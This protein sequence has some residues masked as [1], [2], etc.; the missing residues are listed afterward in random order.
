MS[1]WR[2]RLA[3][4]GRHTPALVEGDP[5]APRGQLAGALE[6]LGWS[7]GELYVDGVHWPADDPLPVGGSLRHGSL[8]GDRAVDQRAVDVGRHVVVVA[9]PA[10]GTIAPLVP[11]CSVVVGREPASDVGRSAVPLA[12][13]DRL[14]SG[15]HCEFAVTAAGGVTVRDLGSR[16]GTRADGVLVSH[17]P[18]ELRAAAI[19]HAGASLLTVLEIAGDERMTLLGSS[20]AGTTVQRQFREAVPPLPDPPRPPRSARDHAAVEGGGAWLRSL[21]PIVTAV[22]MALIT[23]RWWFLAIG[24]LAPLVYG[25]DTLRRARR[26]RLEHTA[27]H[28]RAARD[29]EQYDAV[30]GELRRDETERL[31]G[32]APG[33]AVAAARAR[34]GDRRVWERRPGDADFAS[35]TV[36]YGPRRSAY[37]PIQA[38][39]D[40]PAERERAA[41]L[42]NVPRAVDL[43][44]EGPLAVTGPTTRGRGLL[45]ALVAEIT[46][47]HAPSEVAVWVLTDAGAEWD[48]AR[49]LPHTH[50]A[51]GGARLA[52]TTDARAAATRALRTLID[53]RRERDGRG[54]QHLP[55][56]VVVIDGVGTV[57]T[58]DL[59]AILR[60]GPSVGV[61]AIVADADVV[62]EGARA[63]VALAAHA[64]ETTY[65]SVVNAL[66]D[67]IVVPGLAPQTATTAALAL[68]PLVAVAPGAAGLLGRVR[69]TELL[70]LAGRTPAE[71]AAAWHDRSP[72]TN[73]PVGVA[74]DGT[75]V[76]LDI[77]RH[78]P[79]CLIGGMTRSGKTEF[80]KTWLAALAAHNHPDDLAIAIVDFKGGVDHQALA[81]L[82][83]VVALATNQDLD[84]FE[85]TLTLL[86]AEQQR[87]QRLFTDL[88][89]VATIEGYR[90]AR[91]E[92]PELPPVPRLLVVVDEFAELV[93]APDGRAQLG[94]LE[95]TARI[96]AG[97]GVHLVLL[98]Q[99]F[100]HAL[101]AT[102]DAQ[103][104]LR[105]CFKV[106]QAE[107]SNVVLK[108]PG[109][110]AISAA[111][112]G[113]G[114]ARLQG[115]ELIEFQAARVTN[116]AID[117]APA[118]LTA[119]WQPLEALAGPVAS[120]GAREVPNHLQDLHRVVALLRAAGELDGA[121][122]TPVPWPG[123]LPEL[124]TV[125]ELPGLRP[126]AGRCEGDARIGRWKVA[127]DV[128]IGVADDPARQRV[129]AL[130]LHAADHVVVYAGASGSGHHDALV[131][132]AAQLLRSAS[133]SALHVY[134]ID[135]AGHGLAAI[136]DL[137][138]VGAVATRDDATA[139]R[140]LGHLLTEAAARKG[141]ARCEPRAVLFVLGLDRLHL[142][143]EGIVSP[144]LAP[145]TT[146]VNEVA[147]TGI[148]VIGSGSHAV[149]A[150]R[151]GSAATRRLIFR[152]NDPLDYPPAVSRAVRAGLTVPGRCVDTATGLLAQVVAVETPQ[153]H[154]VPAE[155]RPAGGPRRFGRAPWPLPVDR[156]VDGSVPADATDR[157]PLGLDPDSGEPVWFDPE[158]DGSA[159]RIMGPA[160]SGRSNALAAIGTL[161]AHSGWDVV[162]SAASRRSPLAAGSV[163][164]DELP[165]WLAERV[166]RPTVVLVDDAH[167][168]ADDYPWQRLTAA[169]RAPMVTVVA[170]STDALTR[171]LGLARALGATGGVVLMPTRSR[172]ADPLGVRALDEVWLVQPLA[173]VGVLAMA[174]EARRLQFPRVQ[175]VTTAT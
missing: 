37:Q 128:V 88:A 73:V 165:G 32:A 102:I 29:R 96:G 48:Y 135:A 33:G 151:L 132:T 71:Q 56:H 173:G 98:T 15:A 76:R 166:R 150:N 94:R 172:D 34:F 84:L 19:V 148:Q 123:E 14:L 38:A 167:R 149:L 124:L 81:E 24:A 35:V 120:D 82:P 129:V 131:A 104:G 3:S 65:R 111:H 136:A 61:I 91:Q 101:P 130:E 108:S 62:P 154:P 143:A 67:S 46:F 163:S 20:A 118:A 74:P 107:H 18:V 64:D 117:T 44:K 145:L 28:A 159:L 171:P 99:M 112:K 125:A 95:S 26:R 66:V 59:A 60:D 27:S 153:P 69:L 92:R 68:A 156:L 83:H 106:Q 109:A 52:A 85:R 160:K 157:L 2:V 174:G 113:R 158:E 72:C 8:V 133:C 1:V 25:Y 161:A 175:L 79:H 137:P 58:E 155:S 40:A 147:G 77:V 122:R 41:E 169:G 93:A 23:G 57:S 138:H 103:A 16:N 36:G 87:R 12:V 139:L 140:I 127:R 119:R 152:A 141:G 89:G 42:W 114:I 142:H 146:L 13:D 50:I 121:L 45:R 17:R 31:R 116:A 10:A 134:G 144:L 7:S 21:V 70:G 75:P 49:W 97:L 80:L 30:L 110:A 51:G 5:Q 168:L 11:G 39:D 4:D 100:D 6:A 53:A 78:G 22:G 115:G 86:S 47:A 54:S 170:G 105:V 162:T 43:A 126:S 164:P 63:H 9:G 55:L 90:T